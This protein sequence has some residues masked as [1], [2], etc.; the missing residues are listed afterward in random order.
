[1]EASNIDQAVLVQASGS[2]IEH[3]AYINHCFKSYPNRFLGIGLIP[4]LPDPETHMSRLTED[5]H[6]IGFRLSS[7]GGPT[8]PSEPV[9]IRK[10]K[11]FPIWKY[12]AENDHVLWLYPRASEAHL[13]PHLFDAFPQIRAV[14][15]H[16]MVC[17]TPDTFTWDELGRPQ[18]D[19]P[20][21]PASH[22]VPV[23]EGESPACRYE[24]VA[25]LVSAQYAFSKQP[26]PYLDLADWHQ[27]LFSAFGPDRLMWA[28]DFPWIVNNPGYAPLAGIVEELLPDLS[29]EDHAKLMGETARNFLRFPELP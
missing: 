22:F 23:G 21:P 11:T 27:S 5:G 2:E 3:H 13:L 14:F 8:D 4:N 19:T 28:T 10:F 1:M 24:N 12:A 26:Y 25:V 17:P 18:I 15:N 7:V 9:D 29:P 16:L 6:I 20:M